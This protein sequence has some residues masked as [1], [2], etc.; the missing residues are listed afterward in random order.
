MSKCLLISWLQSPSAVILEPKKIKSVTV[1][2][3]SPSIFH[4]VMG[5]DVMILV[6]WVL[7]FKPAFSLSSFTSPHA[8]AFSLL[9]SIFTSLFPPLPPHFS[10]DKIN[11]SWDVGWDSVP[12]SLSCLSP[13]L[14]SLSPP[15]PYTISSPF[16]SPVSSP[17]LFPSFPF[18]SLICLSVICT[19]GTWEHICQGPI[20]PLPD[21]N[22]NIRRGQW[23]G[24]Q[25]GIQGG[26]WGPCQDQRLDMI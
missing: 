22:E 12:L 14:F 20:F 7:S 10:V 17:L 16:P 25:P 24:D 3:I 6:S 4:E 23:A 2:I 18:S 9:L 11:L 21:K 26:Q 8:S 19:Q 13:S 1:S 5:P 15:F